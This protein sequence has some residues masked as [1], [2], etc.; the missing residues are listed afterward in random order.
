[1][2]SATLDS[3]LGNLPELLA[4][5]VLERRSH[6]IVIEDERQRYVQLLPLENF[7]IVVECVSNAFLSPVDQ[8]DARAHVALA[9]LGLTAP[10]E[11]GSP[12]WQWED[13]GPGVL[14]ASRVA[15]RVLTQVLGLSRDTRVT[16]L[17]RHVDAR[18]VRTPTAGSDDRS[19]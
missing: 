1:M 14:R 19:R 3:A 13:R 12:N 5:L 9:A 16:V 17:D 6:V 7:D 10:S 2:S 4:S 11:A 18:P 8:L 15:E